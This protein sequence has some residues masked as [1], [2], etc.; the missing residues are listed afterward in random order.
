MALCPMGCERQL[1]CIGQ[2]KPALCLESLAADSLEEGALTWVQKPGWFPQR[3]PCEKGTVVGVWPTV[4]QDPE[5]RRPWSTESQA[6]SF[7][8]SCELLWQVSQFKCTWMK[9]FLKEVSMVGSSSAP[10]SVPHDSP[11]QPAHASNAPARSD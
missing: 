10:R 7:G 3:S 8:W 5:A 11:R 2:G 4:W 9:P 1:G 6:R